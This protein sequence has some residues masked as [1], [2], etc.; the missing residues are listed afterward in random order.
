MLK[1][2]MYKLAKVRT[3]KDGTVLDIVAILANKD[4]V[5][6]NS[7]AALRFYRRLAVGWETLN[8]EELDPSII[9]NT[10]KTLSNGVYQ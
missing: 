9:S 6:I 1:T 3:C 5:T 7:L 2:R 10:L 8:G 4:R